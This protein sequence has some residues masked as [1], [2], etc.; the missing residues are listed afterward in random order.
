MALII[1]IQMTHEEPVGLNI[2][3][4]LAT[5]SIKCKTRDNSTAGAF[6]NAETGMSNGGETPGAGYDRNVVQNA[7]PR[8]RS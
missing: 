3:K 4:N 2:V 7:I 1:A 5:S 6:P 8:T